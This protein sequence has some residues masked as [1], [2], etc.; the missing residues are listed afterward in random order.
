MA[1]I[2]SESPGRCRHYCPA[3]PT[4][5][6]SWRNGRIVRTTFRAILRDCA[7]HF[8]LLLTC[9]SVVVVSRALLRHPWTDP[10]DG[11]RGSSCRLHLMF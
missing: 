5:F 10:V 11:H 3:A 1:S 6:A 4:T 7:L 9:I 8:D 2:V